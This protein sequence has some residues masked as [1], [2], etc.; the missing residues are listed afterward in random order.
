[1]VYMSD[2]LGFVLGDAARLLR[3]SFDER[4]RNLGITRPQWRVLALLKRYD[5]STQ[6]NLADMLDVEPITFGRMVDRLQ[7]ASLVERRAD[8]SDRRIWRLHLTGEGEQK[9]EALRPTA[10]MLFEEALAGLDAVQRMELET[11]LNIIRSNL[12]RKPIK[13]SNI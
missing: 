11:M 13:T 1:M 5:G 12:T 9:I 2:N 6:V 7:N 3:R 4:S 10:L 8:P